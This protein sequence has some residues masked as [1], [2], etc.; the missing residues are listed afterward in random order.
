MLELPAP[1]LGG[2]ERWREKVVAVAGGVKGG[3]DEVGGDGP[4]AAQ[5]G[6]EDV[7]LGAGR[8]RGAEGI[9]ELPDAHGD[10]DPREVRADDARRLRALDGGA[11]VQARGGAPAAGRGARL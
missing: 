2:G 11:G 1:A 3:A 4:V 7:E 6:V 9:G 8:G 10:P 5:R